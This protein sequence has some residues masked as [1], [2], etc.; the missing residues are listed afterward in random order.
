[1]RSRFTLTTVLNFGGVGLGFLTS[2]AIT[3]LI[4][5]AL[6][7]ETYGVWLFVSSFAVATG[8]LGILDFGVQSAVVRFVAE[9]H[10]RDDAKT[11][12]Q[13][14]SLALAIFLPL[15][16]LGALAVFVASRSLIFDWFNVPAD[17]HGVARA[18]FLVLAVQTVIDFPSLILS[19]LMDGLQRYDLQRLIQITIIVANALLNV[20]LLQL[21]FGV[22]ALALTALC[23]SGLRTL[24]LAVLIRRVFPQV[25]IDWNVNRQLVGRIATFG[26]EVFLLRLVGIVYLTM[27]KSIISHFLSSSEITPYDIATKLRNIAM[28]TFGVITP[29]IVPV[30]SRLDGRGDVAAIRE[31]FIRATKYQLAV[32][33][34]VVIS[35][36]ILAEDLLRIWLGADWAYVATPAR[37]FLCYVLLDAVVVVGYNTMIGVGKVRPLLAIQTAT[38]TVANVVI[39]VIL[40][41]RI[42]MTGVIFG[43]LIGTALSI[44]PYL[45]LYL[46]TLQVTASEFLRSAVLLPYAIGLVLAIALA[47]AQHYVQPTNVVSLAALGSSGLFLYGIIFW[48]LALNSSERAQALQSVRAIRGWR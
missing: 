43:T 19:A 42:G 35:V 18:L 14:F 47:G 12:N 3:P 36:F 46:R 23:L 30:V 10:G 8:F 27:D 20:V 44:A 9:H 21:G 34:P 16:A 41:P 5:R 40:T 1:M 4:L 11:V 6:G 31:V 17:L 26:T 22:L 7:P 2:L 29:Q 15:G 13:V 32:T 28:V 45:W 39:S 33:L 48:L 24:L 25:G 37:L 38:T